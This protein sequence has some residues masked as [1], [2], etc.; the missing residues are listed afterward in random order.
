[1]DIFYITVAC[2]R[3][4]VRFNDQSDLVNNNELNCKI[5]KLFSIERKAKKDCDTVNKSSMFYLKTDEKRKF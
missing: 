1:M 5:C 2:T 4:V 3:K